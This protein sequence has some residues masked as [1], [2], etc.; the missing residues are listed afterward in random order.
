MCLL[1]CPCLLCFGVPSIHIHLA[2]DNCDVVAVFFS[3]RCYSFFYKWRREEKKIEMHELERHFT[4]NEC[5]HRF[6]ANEQKRAEM[7]WRKKNRSKTWRMRYSAFQAQEKNTA[8][9]AIVLLHDGI[10]PRNSL[11]KRISAS[12]LSAL[13]CSFN[14]NNT[15]SFW[16]LISTIYSLCPLRRI[17]FLFLSSS[18]HTHSL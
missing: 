13:L 10:T 12:V 1:L 8:L 6:T 17:P 16:R 18:T 5:S 7:E 14:T 2:R 3:L 15:I 11:L 9:L 4:H